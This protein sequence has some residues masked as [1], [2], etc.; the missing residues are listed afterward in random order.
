MYFHGLFFFVLLNNLLRHDKYK[1]KSKNRI[2]ICIKMIS[3]NYIYKLN[4]H[5]HLNSHTLMFCSY[6]NDN[7]DEMG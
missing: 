5:L 2:N 1:Y 7:F 3:V 6:T 4:L